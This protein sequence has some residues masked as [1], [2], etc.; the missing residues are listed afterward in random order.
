MRC[1]IW[2]ITSKATI[3]QTKF[4]QKKARIYRVVFLAHGMDLMVPSVIFKVNKFLQLTK[5]N[6]AVVL[7][8]A[9]RS[10]PAY[11]KRMSQKP[12]PSMTSP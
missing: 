9:W 12:P 7:F 2:I 10:S 1:S 6:S 4:P 8:S 3:K 11:L 5:Y